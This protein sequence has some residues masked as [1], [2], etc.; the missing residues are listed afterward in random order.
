MGEILKQWSITGDEPMILDEYTVEREFGWVFFYDS[1]KHQ[2][3]QSFEFALA[4]NAPVIVNRIDGFLHSTGTAFPTEH[5][6]REYEETLE[7]V[8]G[9]WSL[10]VNDWR[11]LSALKALRKALHLS[12]EEIGRLKVLSSNVIRKGAKRDMESLR[13]ALIAEG[14]EAEIKE[15]SQHYGE[16]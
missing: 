4:G 14:V 9:K 12:V 3:T 5:Y 11:S 6:I 13:E 7:R 16:T 10:I 8:G 15:S 1:R 2:E